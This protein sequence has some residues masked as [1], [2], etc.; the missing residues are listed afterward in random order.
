MLFKP[1]DVITIMGKRGSG[2]TT[3]A[4]KIQRCYPRLVIIDRVG[5]YASE[6]GKGVWHVET[7]EGFGRA[8]K[9]TLS[10][11]AFRIFVHFPIESDNHDEFFNQV[12][13]ICYKREEFC[14]YQ[15]SLCIVIDEVQNFARHN[16]I[17]RYFRE[18][19]LTGRHQ[20]LG[21]I[22]C[23]QRPANVHKDI[24]ANSHHIFCS[25]VSEANDLN[26]LKSMLGSAADRLR[27]LK[28][29]HFLHVQDGQAPSVIKS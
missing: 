21:L 14:E 23:S 29:F 15:S 11:S 10:E 4:R 3:L 13:Y 9:A 24:L 8:I 18:V 1:T 2:K 27:G 22:A 17:P 20:N 16:Y 7:M 5:E 12:L 25:N 6:K 26:Y 19:L 28:Q